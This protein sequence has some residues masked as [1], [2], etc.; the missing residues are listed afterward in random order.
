MT[1]TK[2]ETIFIKIK[3]PEEKKSLIQDIV[4][5]HKEIILK[6]PTPTSEGL[7]LTG[8]PISCVRDQLTCR[9]TNYTPE[10]QSQIT[11]KVI[12]NVILQF[13]VGEEK[14]MSLCFA[15]PNGD[16]MTL[17]LDTDVFKIQ[18]REDFRL[19]LPSSYQSFFQVTAI[20]QS[21]AQFKLSINDLSAG[22][23][24]IELGKENYPFKQGDHISGEIQLSKRNP[25]PVTAE[26]KH[27]FTPT[28]KD[29]KT[30]L[31]LQFENLSTIAK[32]RLVGIVMDTYKELFSK[33]Q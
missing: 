3:S 15:S 30:L 19:R 25:I 8:T 21:P 16:S 29:A 11:S 5:E 13:S 1:S 10:I 2:A 9:L 27:V 24:R 14:Y 18:R 17:N 20:N 28:S 6:I 7:I 22:G 32:N 12:E 31:G 26:I 23:C 4:K 33:I